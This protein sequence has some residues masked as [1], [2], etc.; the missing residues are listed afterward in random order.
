M[1]LP[2]LHAAALPMHDSLPGWLTTSDDMEVVLVRCHQLLL[3]AACQVGAGR[4]VAA[5]G[6]REMTTEGYFASRKHLH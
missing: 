4:V 5:A 6:D 2:V 3:A 1:T